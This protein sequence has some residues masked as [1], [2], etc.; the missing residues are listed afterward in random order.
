MSE[1]GEG[2]KRGKAGVGKGWVPLTATGLSWSEAPWGWRETGVPA[3]LEEMSEAQGARSGAK[4]PG[5]GR[6]SLFGL[7][8]PWVRIGARSL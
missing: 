8:P 2:K 5:R 3:Q 6:G 4:D 1:G 7:S